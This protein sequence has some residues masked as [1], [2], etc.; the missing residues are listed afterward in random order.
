M[1][2]VK[3]VYVEIINADIASEIMQSSALAKGSPE[4]SIGVDLSPIPMCGE[5]FIPVPARKFQQ[6][7]KITKGDCRERSETWITVLHCALWYFT[8]SHLPPTVRRPRFIVPERRRQI[9]ASATRPRGLGSP[10]FVHLVSHLQ[11]SAR[12]MQGAQE[13]GCTG[14]NRNM[15]KER[16]AH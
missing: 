8:R 9:D 13:Q 11:S 3:R 14:W 12:Y 2:R 4:Y 6:T 16:L 5:E 15:A 1:G 7:F 10:I